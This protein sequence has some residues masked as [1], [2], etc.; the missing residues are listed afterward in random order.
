MAADLTPGQ[1]AEMMNTLRCPHCTN[2]VE[3]HDQR[4]ASYNDTCVYTEK[5]LN[6]TFY[7]ELLNQVERDLYA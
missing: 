7:G 2:Y 5:Y 6:Y 4:I 3:D 1:I